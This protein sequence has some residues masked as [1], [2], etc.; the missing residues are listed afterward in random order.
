MVKFQI[1]HNSRTINAFP[2][3]NWIQMLPSKC[4]QYKGLALNSYFFCIIPLLT[5]LRDMSVSEQSD[6]NADSSD[7][8][9]VCLP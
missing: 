8:T 5:K 3:K 4:W 2:T 6:A 9:S 1:L 7:L